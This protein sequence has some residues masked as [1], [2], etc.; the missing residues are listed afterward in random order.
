MKQSLVRLILTITYSLVFASGCALTVLFP[1]SLN[2]RPDVAG[3][4]LGGDISIGLENFMEVTVFEDITS[5]PP[6]RTP[7]AGTGAAPTLKTVFPYLPVVNYNLGVIPW[8]NIYYTGGHYGV[9]TQFL[10][11]RGQEGW[12]ASVFAGYGTNNS[13]MSQ[14]TCTGGNCSGEVKLKGLEYGLSIGH[15]FGKA[16]VVYITA[17][18]QAGDAKSKIVQPSQTYEYNEKYEHRLISFGVEFGEQLYFNPEISHASN[19]WKLDT[20]TSTKTAT[21]GMVSVGYKW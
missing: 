14:V 15:G 3:K 10:G 17:G 21:T 12:K 1:G 18:Q 2:Q 11:A 20:S 5:T 7:P 19:S 16:A 13:S 8:M 6:L 4:T 9:K